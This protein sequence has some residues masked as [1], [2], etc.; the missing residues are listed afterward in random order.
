[1]DQKRRE[2][3]LEI[4]IVRTDAS[5][6][7]IL[8]LIE[9]TAQARAASQEPEPAATPAPPTEEAQATAIPERIELVAEREIV[10]RCGEASIT[11]T[12]AGKIILRGTYVLSRSS[13]VNK[14]KGESIQ[15]N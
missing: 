11:L 9:S 12:R 10:L 3:E 7:T 4:E 8:E 6:A 5:G 1:M 13:G 15:I 2:V 14:I